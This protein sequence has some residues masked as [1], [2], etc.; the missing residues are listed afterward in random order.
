MRF[1]RDTSR[2]FVTP[3]RTFYQEV[4]KQKWYQKGLLITI[5][6]ESCKEYLQASLQAD[7]AL[8]RCHEQKPKEPWRSRWPQERDVEQSAPTH[9]HHT[10]CASRQLGTT[11]DWR[12]A[13]PPQDWLREA[14]QMARV[15]WGTHCKGF[16]G[17]E[18]PHYQIEW[19][20]R[21]PLEGDQVQRALEK[22]SRSCHQTSNNQPWFMS[23]EIPWGFLSRA[24]LHWLSGGLCHTRKCQFKNFMWEE[25][26]WFAIAQRLFAWETFGKRWNG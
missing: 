13:V 19:S 7:S 10:H 3:M 4:Y 14:C 2:H 20:A 1:W 21:N 15:C 17:N 24:V 16:H 23:L 9:A 5:L 11:A 25:K 26:V 6:E 18:H 12:Y 8:T 22:L